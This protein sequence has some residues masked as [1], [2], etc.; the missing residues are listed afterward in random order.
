MFSHITLGCPDIAEARQFYDGILRE[1]DLVLKFS[2]EHWAGWKQPNAERPLFIITLPFDGAVSTTGNGQMTAFLA[3]TRAQV[4]ACHS[5]AVTSG[6]KDEGQ[7][8]LRPE[9]HQNYY[10]AY[11]RDPFGNKICVCCH[12]AE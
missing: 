3:Q 11:F 6:G 9:Y 8:G 12:K 5:I 7:P 2:D 1:L 4:N 10:G